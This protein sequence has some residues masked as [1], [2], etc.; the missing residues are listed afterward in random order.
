MEKYG[1]IGESLSHSFSPRYFEQKFKSQQ[2]DAVYEKLE[3]AKVSLLEQVPY[4]NYRG[5]NVT[6]PYKSSI[7]TFCDEVDAAADDIGA[8]NTLKIN[9]A[10]TVT[11][12][13]TDW[14]GF[15]DSIKPLLKNSDKRAIIFGTGGSSK[16]VHY[17]LEQM[18]IEP[19][20]ISRK[21]LTGQ[22]HYDALT[23][24]FLSKIQIIINTTPLGMYPDVE[25]CPPVSSYALNEQHLVYDLI[26][27]PEETTLLRRAKRC[28]CRIKNGYEM[29]E[30][31]AEASWEIWNS[32][33]FKK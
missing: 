2:I 15:R 3:I 33:N 30:K 21:P 26:Y 13:N 5:L 16:A 4:Q 14:I 8:V 10:G 31:Q 20:R 7:I 18:N 23:P 22:L 24:A 17:A 28:G 11:G 6:I 27:N 9:D 1:L 32:P 29:L 19:V 12:Y 25:S